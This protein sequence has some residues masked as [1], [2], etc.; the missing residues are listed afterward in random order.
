MGDNWMGA[1]PTCGHELLE[2]KAIEIFEDRAERPLMLTAGY[3]ADRG[4]DLDD[5]AR[6]LAETAR[7]TAE[8]HREHRASRRAMRRGWSILAL[9]CLVPLAG[10]AA[11]PESVVRATPAA[12]RIYSLAGMEVNAFGFIIRDA[13]SELQTETGA[14]LLAV[15]GEVV[16]VTDTAL[17][18][19]ALRFVLRDRSGSETY[20]WTLDGVGAR[21]VEPGEATSFRTRVAAPPAH[22]E[23]VEIR[24][25]RGD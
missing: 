23:D 9:A 24:F 8:R 13:A 21:N 4:T 10:A 19:P 22:V 12:A 25:A 6:R 18:V 17:P 20:A 1:C 16:N 2:T 5:E 15:R 14:P 7:L 11:F 3:G